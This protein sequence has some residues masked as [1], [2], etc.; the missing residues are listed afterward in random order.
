MFRLGRGEEMI[1]RFDM[2][3][4]KG[5]YPVQ[6]SEHPAGAW[7]RYEDVQHIIENNTKLANE[8]AKAIKGH[9]CEAQNHLTKE[10]AVLELVSEGWLSPEQV[11]AKIQ[12]MK[13]FSSEY[14]PE[15]AMKVNLS[16]V[17]MMSYACGMFDLLYKLEKVFT[18]GSEGGDG[19]PQL[20]SPELNK[21]YQLQEVR[22]NKTSSCSET[23]VVGSN[24]ATSNSDTPLEFVSEAEDQTNKTMTGGGQLLRLKNGK[25]TVSPLKTK[26]KG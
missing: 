21:S 2:F 22:H 17:Q 24:P 15:Y 25:V 12:E 10:Q 7:V 3:T 8:W 14:P 1:K 13:T 4:P 20:S 18:Y 11:K 26:K 5:E 19:K 6:E 23:D 16:T 9:S